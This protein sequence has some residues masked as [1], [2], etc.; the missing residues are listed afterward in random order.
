MAV[1]GTGSF[2]DGL[3]VRNLRL[4][5]FDRHLV[6]VLYAPLECAEMEFTLTFDKGLFQFLALLD[7][8][9]RVFF[10]HTGEYAG[11][12]FRIAFGYGTYGTCEFRIR[13][14]DEVELPVDAFLV[15]RVACTNIFEFY[16]AS[17][18]ACPQFFNRISQLA[19]YSEDLGKTLLSAA[20]GVV[21]VNSSFERAAH[22]LE[23]AY[24]ADVRLYGCLKEED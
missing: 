15:E 9:C 19:A 3:T 14:F 8:P 6:I 16:R 2:S 1:V 22:H 23:I 13:I 18:V 20:C 10:M 7:D 21:E 4:E 17:D 24:F 11:K 5:E 12:F